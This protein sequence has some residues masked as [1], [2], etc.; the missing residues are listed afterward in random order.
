MWLFTR[1]YVNLA[2]RCRKLPRHR[3]IHPES[4]DDFPVIFPMLETARTGG[5]T[6]R[7]GKRTNIANWKDPPFSMGKS[8]I[9]MTIF[10]SK[11]LVYQ[12]VT[13][14]RRTQKRP[15]SKHGLWFMVIHPSKDWVSCIRMIQSICWLYPMIISLISHIPSY[16]TMF[17]FLS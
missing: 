13:I 16:T 3:K 6:T 8:T 5:Y 1:G 4:F 17:S 7:P 9:S 12:R 14:F 15:C 11:L 10:N 2:S